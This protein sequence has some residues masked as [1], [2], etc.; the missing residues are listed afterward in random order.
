MHAALRSEGHDHKTSLNQ[1]CISK[2]LQMIDQGLV[3]SVSTD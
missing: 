1:L 3:P 2:L